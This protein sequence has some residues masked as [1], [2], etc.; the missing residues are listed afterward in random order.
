MSISLTIL[1]QN[2][3]VVFQKNLNHF[4]KAGASEFRI[5]YEYVSFLIHVI[6]PD[7]YLIGN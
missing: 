7:L 5:T 3:S 2:I 6:S 1:G 4:T